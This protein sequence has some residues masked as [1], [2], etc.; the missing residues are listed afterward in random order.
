MNYNRTFHGYPALP[1]QLMVANGVLKCAYTG[2]SF[3][4]GI[5]DAYNKYTKDFNN[6]NY[7]A[8]QEF[9]LDQRNRY[10]HMVMLEPFE[11]VF[12]KDDNVKS[13]LAA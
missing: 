13:G 5:T 8:T 4:N 3:S 12:V 2:R 7:R 6:T 9:L 11:G 10:L 1:K